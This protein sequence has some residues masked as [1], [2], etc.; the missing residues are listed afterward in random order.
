MPTPLRSTSPFSAVA[1]PTAQPS[2]EPSKAPG[3]YILQRGVQWKQG[4]VNYMMIYTILLYNT[5][6]ILC[7]VSKVAAPY[8]SVVANL[9]YDPY[10]DVR[11]QAGPCKA[12]ASFQRS[13]PEK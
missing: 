11:K 12:T 5:T 9:L 3:V 4:V 2:P 10:A 8:A 7:R 1:Q 6:P 13:N